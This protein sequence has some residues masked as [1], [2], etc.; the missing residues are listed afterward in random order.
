LQKPFANIGVKN[1]TQ[2][3]QQKTAF[4]PILFVLAAAWLLWGVGVSL[5]IGYW[6]SRQ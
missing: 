3:T 4:N 2:M 1:M 6:A 5:A